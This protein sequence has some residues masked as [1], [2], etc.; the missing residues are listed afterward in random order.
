MG[1][2]VIVYVVS[3]YGLYSWRGVLGLVPAWVEVISRPDVLVDADV[4]QVF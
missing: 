1:L 2:T 4:N 3:S